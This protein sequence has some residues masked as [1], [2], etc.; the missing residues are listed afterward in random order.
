MAATGFTPISLYYSSTT[1]NVPTAGNLVAG[2]LALNTAD[3]K[4][5]YKDS[6]NVVQV[7]GTKGGVGTSSTT[8]VLYNSSGLVVGSSAF[9]FDGSAINLAA[10]T[11]IYKSTGVGS[12]SN[13]AGP[14]FA[15]LSNSTSDQYYMRL[16]GSKQLSFYGYDQSNSG[17]L[18]V[19]LAIADGGKW[20]WFTAGNERMR[21]D[22]SGNVGIGVTPSTWSTGKTLQLGH[23]GNA[24]LFGG[25]SAGSNTSYGINAYFNSGWKYGD[26]GF[27]SRYSQSAADGNHVWFTAPSGTAGNAVTFTQALTLNNN[28]A[29]ALQGASTSANGVG[30]TF[31][32]TQ[33]ASSDAN[34]LDDYEE[35]TWTPTITAQTGSY[36]TVTNQTGSYTKIGRQVT[37]NWY[38]IVSNKGT[39]LSGA[40][41]SNLPFASNVSAGNDYSG[42]G[43]D[44]SAAIM[45][46][47]FM[48]GTTSFG[49]Y[50][51]TGTDPIIAGRGN[52]GTL[53]YFTS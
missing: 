37:I 13:G 48:T 25:T 34:T 12:D 40:T 51:V 14:S 7:I 17:N 15:I 20:Q 8:Q 26:T 23:V 18:W 42:S 39:G 10:T 27:A 4:L 22:S 3:G 16:N 31:P 35:G 28:G 52:F 29:L 43:A 53:T 41:I 32:A 1:T 36:T 24:F 9:T 6:S 5:F 50:S 19:N 11:P 38:F 2:E 21:I 30:I 44:T 45:Q 33:S 47:A 46:L 49:L